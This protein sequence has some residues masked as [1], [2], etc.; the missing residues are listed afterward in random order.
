MRLS[1][2]Y[3]E[4]AITLEDKADLVRTVQ[5][6]PGASIAKELEKTIKENPNYKKMLQDKGVS[7]N[8]NED[9]VKYANA[10]AHDACVN[11][12]LWLSLRIEGANVEKYYG[13]FYMKCVERGDFS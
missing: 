4:Y 10:I 8:T 13:D 3:D 6:E 9:I 5:Q 11:V 2:V 7:L 1:K 12:N